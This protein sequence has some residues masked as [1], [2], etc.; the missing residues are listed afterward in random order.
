LENI[1]QILAF[2]RSGINQFLSFWLKLL[3]IRR[4]TPQLHI[5]RFVYDNWV[6]SKTSDVDFKKRG[7]LAT[8]HTPPYLGLLI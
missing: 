2:Q 4:E 8:S 5:S 3:E 6:V 7:F 1:R